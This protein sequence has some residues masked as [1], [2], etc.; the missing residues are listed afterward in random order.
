MRKCNY[1]YLYNI[2]NTEN[3]STNDGHNIYAVD[4]S[5][6]SHKNNDQLWVVGIVCTTNKSLFRCIYTKISNS[7][8][9]RRFITKYLLAGNTICSDGLAGYN[10]MNND[11][12]PYIHMSFNLGGGNWGYG[13]YSTAHIEQIWSV[14]KK[15]IKST[16]YAIPSKGFYFYLKEAEF[17]YLNRTKNKF[18]IYELIKEVL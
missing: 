13:I 5:L 16:Y 18:Q 10:F 14:L 8:Y 2:Y 12:S 17:K 1:E 6:F 7:Q 11:N 4:E 15:L 3:I 9:L